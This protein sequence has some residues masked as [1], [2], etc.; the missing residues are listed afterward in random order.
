[1]ATKVPPEQ[2]WLVHGI[3]AYMLVLV[4]GELDRGKREMSRAMSWSGG[5]GPASWV[6]AAGSQSIEEFTAHFAQGVLTI[7]EGYDHYISAVLRSIG[8]TA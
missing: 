4:D 2:A 6:Q 7:G 5:K 8:K 3:T 1:M